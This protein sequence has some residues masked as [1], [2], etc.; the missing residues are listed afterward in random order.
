MIF[1][2]DRD[3]TINVDYNFVHKKEE[4]TFC[5]GAPE[6]IRLLN[7]AGYRVVVVTNQTGII[8]EHFTLAQVEALHRWVDEELAKH[9]AR[10]DAW[11]IAPWRHNMHE[12]R[13]P[14]L[15]HDRK[16]GTGMF[17][18]AMIRYNNAK[19]GASGRSDA[20]AQS[21]KYSDGTV[22]KPSSEYNS[23]TKLAQNPVS[24][25]RNTNATQEATSDRNP[26][27]NEKPL[28]KIPNNTV[29]V[30][31]T[32]RINSR[33]EFEIT[34]IDSSDYTPR[35][36]AEREEIG[37]QIGDKYAEHFAKCAM[38]GDKMRDL[39]PAIR[40]GMRPYLIKSVH[41][42]TVDS[43]WMEANSIP[44]YDRLLDAVKHELSRG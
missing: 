27:P 9:G 22:Q 20:V 8:R 10:I 2:L 28:T 1:F 16:P 17:E 29:S 6:A 38:A 14:A 18:R 35:S 12:D 32:V 30:Y 15:L 39:D 4:W 21:D 31:E 40:L 37:L 43:D 7:E 3:G 44:V 26:S 19:A 5:D 24:E 23:P 25:H 42:D 36:L 33:G 13:H 11:Y 41:F 34:Q